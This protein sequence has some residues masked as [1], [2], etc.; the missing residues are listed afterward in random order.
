MKS[1]F[2]YSAVISTVLF[3]PF[4]MADFSEPFQ[5]GSTETVTLAAGRS[6]TCFVDDDG[7]YALSRTVK[8][9]DGQ[10][11]I[12]DRPG[13]NADISKN[14]LD[15]AEEYGDSNLSNN[16]ISFKSLP[17]QDGFGEY[18]VEM[19]STDEGSENPFLS[20]FETT[21]ACSFNTSVNDFNFLEVTNLGTQP[22]VVSYLAKDFTGEIFTATGFIAPGK[23]ADF[24]IHSQV[25]PGKFG[26][27][28][29]QPS[30]AGDQFQETINARLSQYKGNV[31][32][33][34]EV[35][36]PLPQVD[37]FSGGER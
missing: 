20:C 17:G 16:I 37:N 21:L 23:R 25:G 22:A 36:G 12:A 11:I 7:T 2:F 1:I 10:S 35:C 13:M 15:D 32:S 5:A 28:V 26:S 27:I 29:V 4:A 6:Y 33:N 24:D 31:L 34:T 3:C 30:V 9:P 8:A 19:Q 14:R 18:T